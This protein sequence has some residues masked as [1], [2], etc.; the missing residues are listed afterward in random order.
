[1]AKRSERLAF[2]KAK[3]DESRQM[4]RYNVSGRVLFA[5][6]AKEWTAD[7]SV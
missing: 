1:V 7:N 5:Q 3:V 2:A 6:R 4:T